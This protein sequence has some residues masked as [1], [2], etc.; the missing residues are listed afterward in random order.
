MKNR[1]EKRYENS[2]DEEHDLTPAEEIFVKQR[3]ELEEYTKQTQLDDIIEMPLAQ[4]LHQL[5]V[6]LIQR[7]KEAADIVKDKKVKG[8]PFDENNLM[9]V[10]EDQNSMVK[11]MK[12]IR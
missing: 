1:R 4:I 11:L 5:G 6:R 2:S 8:A 7:H 9:S 3:L 12:K 10:L